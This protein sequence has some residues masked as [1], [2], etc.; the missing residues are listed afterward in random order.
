MIIIVAEDM[1]REE[2]TPHGKIGMS[3]AFRLTAEIP[4][5]TLEF[6]K[7]ILH[8]GSAIGAHLIDHDEVYYVI[9]GEGE[10][11]SNEQ[12]QSLGPGMM[13]Y[14]YRGDAVGIRQIGDTPLEMI[15]SYPLA[16]R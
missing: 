2:A 15:I 8:P 7:R 14:L 16:N 6:R 3:T 9:S 11:F 12:A 5:R 13:A 4:N 1:R 10:V